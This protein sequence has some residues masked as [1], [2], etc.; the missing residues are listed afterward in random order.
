MVMKYKY[1][2]VDTDFCDNIR[3]LHPDLSFRLATKKLNDVLEKLIYGT[4][5][6]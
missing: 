3:K 2:R 5:L 1:Q 6:K 4:K